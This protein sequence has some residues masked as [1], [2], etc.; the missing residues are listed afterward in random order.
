MQ[1]MAKL[2][3]LAVAGLMLGC[4]Q[5]RGGEAPKA[6]EAEPAKVEPARQEPRRG[7]APGAN[8]A[9]YP[10]GWP[11]G[12]AL[13]VERMFP[14]EV[15]AG[16]T[17]EYGLKV[18]NVAG[19]ALHEVTLTESIPQGFT[20]SGTSP[21]GSPSADGKS[22]VFALGNFAPGESKTVRITG[23]ARDVSAIT[24][25]ASLSYVV[26]VCQSIS[27][28]KP[29]LALTLSAPAEVLLCDVIPLKMVVT[30]SGT[31]VARNV[32]VVSTLP[33][34]LTVDGQSNVSFDAGTL[35]AGQSREVVVNARA[36]RRGT[37]ENSG[38]ASAE[39]GLAANSN[40]ARTVVRQPELELKVE[41]PEN[42]LVGRT[43]SFRFT[44]TNKG[45]GVSANT[46]LTA[47]VPAGSAFVSAEGGGAVQNNAV[48]WNLGA[49]APSASRSVTM[50]VR[51]AG[52]GT[53]T[54]SGSVTGV[55]ANT[56]TQSCSTGV[57]GTPDMATLLDDGEGVV[58][59]GA[60]HT[61]RYEVTNQ[62]QVDLTNVRTSIVLPDG[63]EFVSATLPGQPTRD[64]RRLT[65]TAASA[66]KPGEKR[67]FNIVVRATREGEFLVV[68][69][70]TCAELRSAVRDD[71]ITVFIPR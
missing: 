49:L 1:K 59:V 5:Q 48:V 22:W 51:S 40:P 38:R 61:Y 64:G 62:G 66:L 32:R 41:C 14:A 37:Y 50:V 9:Y 27:V 65:W 19:M 56:A 45:D 15:N 44:V 20:A 35:A 16:A 55:C 54:A 69:E 24:S 17:F 10:S 67:T 57:R 63:L 8:V 53:L 23:A 13:S 18:T 70:T 29:A 43:A 39:G 2:V 21:Q 47:P 68:S 71:E 34:G 7:P 12:A 3:G 25:C 33:A 60:N 26:P 11:Q 46:T 42:V 36:A 6:A 52:A 58:L 30:N 31:G 28:V 4:A